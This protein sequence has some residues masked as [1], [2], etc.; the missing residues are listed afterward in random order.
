MHTFMLKMYRDPGEG[1]GGGSGGEGGGGQ[2]GQGQQQTGA[3]GQQGQQG[4]Q[5][6]GEQA[7]QQRQQVQQQNRRLGT[8]LQKYLKTP[9]MPEL[10]AEDASKP[11]TQADFQRY[12]EHTDRVRHVQGFHNDLME[13]V[14]RPF[15]HEQGDI[16]LSHAFDADEQ[17]DDFAQFSAN[18]LARGPSARQ[19]RQLHHFDNF[20]QQAYEAG[21]KAAEARLGQNKT[22]AL[23]TGNGQQK[24]VTPN[25]EQVQQQNNNGGQKRKSQMSVEDHLK[26]IDP[27]YHQ[28]LL[29]GEIDL[30]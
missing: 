1:G 23:Q 19:L 10:K 26:Q 22:Q 12:Q 8:R 20:I 28:K 13:S 4:Q 25:K 2:Q 14:D 30:A 5:K 15:T 6:T 7:Q 18:I 27:E 11:L 21:A 16:K 29:K 17:V 9:S 3:E 24:V